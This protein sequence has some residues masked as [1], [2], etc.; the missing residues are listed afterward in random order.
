[1]ALSRRS[2]RTRFT[3]VLLILTSITLLTLDFR[4]FPPLESARSAVLGVFAPVGDFFSGLFRPVGNAWTSAFDA[5]DIRSQNEQLRQQVADLE[6]RLANNESAQKEL[7]QLKSQLDIPFV[8]Q[9]P[10]VKARIASGA[11]A[12]FD[13]TVEID[14]GTGQGVDKGMPVVSGAGLVGTVIRASDSRA[15]VKL[16]T[17][18]TTNVGVKVPGKQGFGKTVGQGDPR[19]LRGEFDRSS[20]V[21][22]GDLLVTSGAARSIYPEGIPV[23]KVTSLSTNDAELRKDA[24]V[25][26]LVDLN[27]LDFVTV[28]QWRP[29][30]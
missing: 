16:I 26:T 19:R 18:R 12:N 9:I 4:G 22:E 25:E 10:T 1:M 15:V 13:D 2:S 3:L 28:L 20:A 17:D 7:E 5:D 27:D 6:G 21:A 30:T 11:I 29:P 23:G 8:G 24:D 14:K